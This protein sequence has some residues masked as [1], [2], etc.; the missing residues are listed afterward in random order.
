[1]R[2]AFSPTTEPAFHETASL[3]LI[4]ASLPF[5]LEMIVNLG[6]MSPADVGG[7]WW[8]DRRA[9]PR[10][11]FGLRPTETDGSLRL[12]RISIASQSHAPIA[13]L[14]HHRVRSSDSKEKPNPALPLLQRHC[15]RRR[16]A[17]TAP[18]RE[19]CGITGHGASLRVVYSGGRYGSVCGGVSVW[20]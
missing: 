5:A 2:A 18:D 12:S 10:P 13:A 11:A 7:D 16:A 17:E 6:Q 1:M 14:H 3:F 15:L 19:F 9:A 20:Q 4:P 8:L